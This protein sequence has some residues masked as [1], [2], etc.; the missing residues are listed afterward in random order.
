MENRDDEDLP[1]L[2]I[3]QENEFKKLKLS[4]EH[5]GIFFNKKN[6]NIPPEIEGQF[7]DYV[8]NFENS[9]KNS[10]RI[11]VFEK[12]GKPAFKIPEMLTDAEITIELDTIIQ[13][14]QSFDIALDLICNYADEERLIYTFIVTE[15]FQQEI[16]DINI[17]GMVTHFIY[18][19]F[20]QNHKYDLE[21]ATIDFLKMF[22]NKKSTFYKDHHSEDA[23]NEA[24]IN[25]F[26]DLFDEFE[27]QLF[28]ISD[29][30]F[31]E[32]NALVQ[33][34]IEFSAQNEDHRPK[35]SY[36]G[37]GSISFEY[38]FGYWYIKMVHLPI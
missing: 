30:A 8:S 3:E 21:V 36:S 27:L 19:D 24:E 17:D 37:D 6:P 12:M 14:M 5:G 16:E 9:F 10:I 7:L 28:E 22:L 13:I 4:I 25:L 34:K 35:I 31:N 1:K 26:R 2:T 33:F 32:K 38:E 20:H 18:E 23:V 29:I 15:L 11:T